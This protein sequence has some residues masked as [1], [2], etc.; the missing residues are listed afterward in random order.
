MPQRCDP[1]SELELV[2]GMY[3]REIFPKLSSKQ[4]VYV[5]PGLFGDSNRSVAEQD[6]QL[7]HKLSQYWQWAQAESRI[8]GVMPWHY[9][10]RRQSKYNLK[11]N[12]YEALGVEAFPQ[13]RA[14]LRKIS[15]T[16]ER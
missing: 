13:V 12:H 14:L 11:G 4:R 3:D 5:V 10:T 8:I 16:L 6:A 2:R 9:S 7:V 15:A 1:L